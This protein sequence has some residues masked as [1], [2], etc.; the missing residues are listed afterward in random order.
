[1]ASLFKFPNTL[2]A[3]FYCN[4]SHTMTSQLQWCM[5]YVAIEVDRLYSM[6]QMTSIQIHI[7]FR[8]P[9]TTYTS[10]LVDTLIW[11]LAIQYS[12]WLHACAQIRNSEY[13]YQKFQNTYFLGSWIFWALTAA[14]AREGG[15]QLGRTPTSLTKKPTAG[16]EKG[17]VLHL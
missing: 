1:M 4:T 11:Q 16:R 7:L 5:C 13:T 9:V 14:N 2:Q 3:Q 10:I 17:M 6:V 12:A 8:T 15:Q